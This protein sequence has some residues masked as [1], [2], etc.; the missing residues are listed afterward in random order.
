MNAALVTLI[1]ILSLLAGYRFY[2]KLLSSKVFKTD[3]DTSP[4]PATVIN[5]GVDYV[6]TKKYV[7]FGH[8]FSSIAGAAPILGPAIAIIWGWLP[9]LLWVV[10]G[11]ILM[12]AVHDYGAL[13]LSAKHK[14]KSM[15]AIAESVIGKRSKVLFL[16]I[17]FLE[18]LV[19]DK[20]ILFDFQNFN[21]CSFF[22]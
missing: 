22:E 5:D 7:L 16:T 15:G 17:I 20:N 2:A 8:H 6:P 18:I 4:T 19:L 21:L 11:S 13:V 14:G 3:G 9:A 10:L 1:C 12:G